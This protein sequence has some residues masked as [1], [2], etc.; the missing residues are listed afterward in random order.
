MRWAGKLTRWRQPLL[1]S[2]WEQLIGKINH[3]HYMERAANI[4]DNF[5]PKSK[6]AGNMWRDIGTDEACPYKFLFQNIDFNRK[7]TFRSIKGDNV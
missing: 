7:S 6:R 2:K 4:S 3:M 1:P 5:R